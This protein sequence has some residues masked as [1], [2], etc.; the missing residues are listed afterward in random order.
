[1]SKWDKEFNGT[2]DTSRYAKKTLE[3]DIL[4]AGK[5]EFAYEGPNGELIRDLI[6]G[7]LGME[8]DII[9]I[10]IIMSVVI[11]EKLQ[12]IGM[13]IDIVPI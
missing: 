3:D 6:F 5:G 11:T 12:M 1:M 8:M 9:L 10:I 13:M 7:G 4:A 2:Y